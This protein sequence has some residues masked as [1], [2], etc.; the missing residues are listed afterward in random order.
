MTFA[1]PLLLVLGLLVV[2]A[3]TALYVSSQRRRGA[4]QEAFASPAFVPAVA[5]KR[6]RGRRHVPVALYGLAAAAL[7][8]AVAKPEKTVAV[9]VEQASI[10]LVTDH[11]RSMTATDIAPDRL[12]AARGAAGKLLDQVPDGVKVG[13]V[14]FN[15]RARLLQ[16]PTTDRG[17]VRDALAGLT[18]EGGTATG[19]GVFLGLAAVRAPALPGQ[20]PT[21]AAL[22][23]LTDGKASNGRDVLEVA[24]QAEEAGI[25]VHT[26]ALGT[27]SGSLPGGGTVTT[28]LEGLR[29]VAETSGGQ[30]RTAE[31]AGELNAVYD[32]LGSRLSTKDERRQVT[33]A[34]VG[35][36]LLLLIAGAGFSLFSFGR[37]P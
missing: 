25:P 4:R 12:T 2:A 6:P 29:R 21:P 28:D 1:D 13:A 8:I 7:A 36:G 10:M 17:A 26:V 5:P 9:P 15:Q 16:A 37:L 23:L 35:A 20:K 31:N 18:A 32:E 19:E 33:Q 30:F 3:A 14:A 27:R 34:A 22:V 11:S 24:R